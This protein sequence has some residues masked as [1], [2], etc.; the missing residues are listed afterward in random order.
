MHF[1]I[2]AVLSEDDVNNVKLK[3]HAFNQQF[4]QCDPVDNIAVFAWD[5]TNHKCGSLI[6]MT[7]GYWL[8]VQLLWVDEEQRGKGIGTQLLSRAEFTARERGCRYALIDTFNFQAKDFYLS[9]GY[10][11]KMTL[12]ACPVNQQRYYLTKNLSDEFPSSFSQP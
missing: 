9:R 10:H 11:T 4:V 12:D 8:Q 6:G 1:N 3:L 5:D 2:T 7:W